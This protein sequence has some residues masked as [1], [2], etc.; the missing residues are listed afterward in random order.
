MQ[1]IVYRVE[2]HDFD[3]C[4]TVGPY[5]RNSTF[6]FVSRHNKSCVECEHEGLYYRP[7]PFSDRLERED[8]YGFPSLKKLKRWFGH[9]E[10]QELIAAGFHIGVYLCDDIQLG[11]SLK[12][13]TFRDGL[14]I[15]TIKLR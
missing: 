4:E 13:C 11:Y 12:Q 8:R 1:R 10:R 14:K 15:R 2:Q 7:G 5:R 6:G 3:R 9:K